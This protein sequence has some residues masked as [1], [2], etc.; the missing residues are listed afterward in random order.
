MP[1]LASLPAD[2]VYRIATFAIPDP[3][4]AEFLERAGALQAFLRQQ[5][6]LIDVQAFERRGGPGKMDVVSNA[7]WKGQAAMDAAGRAL[8]AADAAG[9]FDRPAYLARLGITS[10]TAIFAPLAL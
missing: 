2:A 6:G 9:G 3:S 7:V 1:M 8:A 4:L 5:A 10:E